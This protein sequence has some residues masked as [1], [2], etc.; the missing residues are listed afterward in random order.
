MLFVFSVT[1]KARLNF[2]IGIRMTEMFDIIKYYPDNY[3]S[4]SFR[5]KDNVSSIS[6]HLINICSYPVTLGCY[7]LFK[8]F[9]SGCI[10]MKWDLSPFDTVFSKIHRSVHVFG[11]HG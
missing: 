9:D 2:S 11:S 6:Y 10:I 8:K 1:E 7:L 3:S 4:L 5:I